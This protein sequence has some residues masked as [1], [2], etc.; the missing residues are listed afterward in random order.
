M[1]IPEPEH[2][3]KYGYGGSLASHPYLIDRQF[4]PLATRMQDP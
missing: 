2:P 1:Y 4:L 3:I